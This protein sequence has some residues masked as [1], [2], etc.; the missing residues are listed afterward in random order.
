MTQDKLAARL[1]LALALL[2][3]ARTTAFA[4]AP[5]SDPKAV[6]VADQVMTTLGGQKA[7]EA[8]HWIHF[9]F[10]GFRNHWWDKWTGRHRV[11]FINQKG[12]HW[13]IL[14]N[15]NTRE[16][17]AWKDGKELAGE[18][19][20]QV[21]SRGYA[22]WINDTYWLLAPYKLRDPGVT[23][24]LDGEETLNGQGYD[25]LHL[26][27]E[28]VGLTPGDQYWMWV[29]KSNHLVDRWAY[30]LQ[31]FKPD[32]Q[33]VAWDWKEWQR[34][35]SILLSP[36]RYNPAENKS[37]LLDHIEVDQPMADTVFTSAEAM[38]D[39]QK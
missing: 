20:K 27:F 30:K 26:S 21:V 32:Q 36:T 3:A 10:A 25:K 17:R 14:E 37:I 15:L 16:G 24:T 33:P 35:G 6:A 2:L 34:F 13:L 4:E 8:T 28:G 39:A 12:E 18:E 23:L 11:E 19:A 9:R 22:T 31:D 5:G 1:G 29:N 7:W 38:V